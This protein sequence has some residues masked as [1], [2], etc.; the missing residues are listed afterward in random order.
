MQEPIDMEWPS[1]FLQYMYKESGGHP[2]LL[3]YL[4][5]HVCNDSTHL[6]EDRLKAAVERF[7]RE[8]RWQFNEW[9]TRYCTP[10]AQRV[11]AR[12]PDDGSSVSLRALVR[13]FGL[14]DVHEALEILLHVGLITS[15]DDGFAFRNSSQMFHRWYHVFGTLT[16]APQHDPG[17]HL[18]LDSINHDLAGKY[19]ASWRIYQS[20]LPNY[21]GVLVELRGVLEM[22]V[23]IY[24]P[25]AVVKN[26]PGFALETGQSKPTMRQRIRYM[27]RQSYGGEMT[28]QIVSDFNILEV[29]IEQLTQL[30]QHLADLG[31][32][33]HRSAS[34]MAHDT[35]TREMA[36]RALKQWDG[37]L[38]QLLPSPVR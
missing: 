32:M 38:A 12:M 26:Q 25:D 5:Q 28:K 36:Y 35:A 37:L 30:T 19:L 23:D 7:D 10:T 3:Q 33:A 9:W 27:A 18:R 14:D 2:M 15:E 29:N 17:L 21:S 20:D 31:T 24:A 11:Y 13:E 8:R 34:G 22:L 4:M 1:S 16:E 6:V